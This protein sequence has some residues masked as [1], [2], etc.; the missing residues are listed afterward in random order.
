MTYRC[1]ALATWITFA[2]TL[3][4][5][6]QSALAGAAPVAQTNAQTASAPAIV[7]NSP[8]GSGSN[9]VTTSAV[10][11]FAVRGNGAAPAF[12]LPLPHGSRL[13]LQG[14]SKLTVCCSSLLGSCYD[15]TREA[16]RCG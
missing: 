9:A 14:A 8:T 10:D 1:V 7:G 4:L 11:Q 5:S 13:S 6:G 3:G 15:L 12:Q 2:L 16:T